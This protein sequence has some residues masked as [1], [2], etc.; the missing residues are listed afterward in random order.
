M[1]RTNH[2]KIRL[3]S[4]FLVWSQP[5]EVVDQA[6]RPDLHGCFSIGLREEY[7]KTG[8]EDGTCPNIPNDRS[9]YISHT[10]HAAACRTRHRSHQTAR[11]T[12]PA[13]SGRTRLGEETG[14]VR[15]HGRRRHAYEADHTDHGDHS[16]MNATVNP[17]TTVITRPLLV[18]TLRSSPPS[19]GVS[20]T[21]L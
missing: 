7:R 5:T 3:G 4:V 8:R 21:G 6:V 16:D 9:R 13:S 19:D 12:R 14:S 1:G 10:A 17:P 2:A 11:L 18:G 20:P 15:R